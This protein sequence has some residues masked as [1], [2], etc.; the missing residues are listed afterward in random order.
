MTPPQGTV[1][2]SE[3]VTVARRARGLESLAKKVPTRTWEANV[4][5]TRGEMMH[6]ATYAMIGTSR[7]KL[8]DTQSINIFINCFWTP[9]SSISVGVQG[10]SG[11]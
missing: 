2:E 5:H 8:L 3:I 10:V 4:F 1:T 6:N 9:S 7:A 11:G